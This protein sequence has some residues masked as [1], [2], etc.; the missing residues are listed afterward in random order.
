V[1]VASFFIERD[2][3]LL[4]RDRDFAAFEALRGLRGWRH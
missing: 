2:Y 4:H 1:L 3:L